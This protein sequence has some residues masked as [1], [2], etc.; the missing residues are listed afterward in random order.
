MQDSFLF[1]VDEQVLGEVDDGIFGI[2]E[3]SATQ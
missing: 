3:S 2:L 1:V